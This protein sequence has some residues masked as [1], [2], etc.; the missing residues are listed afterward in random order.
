MNFDVQSGAPLELSTQ[1]LVVPVFQ[2]E[3]LSGVAA[4]LDTRLDGLV[5]EVKNDDGFKGAC[6]ETRVLYTNGKIASSR[7]ILV[8]LGKREKISATT[9][10]KAAAKAARGVRALKR[11]SFAFVVPDG[12]G[13]TSESL[14]VAL[15]EGIVLGL[16]IF[17]DFKTDAESKARTVIN[18]VTLLVDS[19]EERE[20]VARGVEYAQITTAANLRTRH[21]VNTPSNLKWPQTLADEAQK[22]ADEN[23][24][25]CT[26]WDENRIQAERMGALWGVGMGSD[27]PPRFIILEHIPQ[28]MENEPPLILVGKGMTFDTGG[29]SLKPSTSMEDMKDDMGGAAAVLGAMSVIGQLKPQRRIMALVASAENMVNGHAQRPGDIVTARNGKT[30]EVLNTDAEGRLILADT[31][32]YATEQKPAAIIDMATLT[33]A[34]GIALGQEAA[35]LFTNNDE[36]G[37]KVRAAGEAVGERVW[38]FPMWD[39]YREHVKGTASDIKNI[40]IERRA[41]SIA[42]AV[43]LEHF[44]GEGIPWVHL[45]I[46]AVAFLREDRPLVQ[47]GA[48]GFGARLILELLRT[49]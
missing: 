3:E 25:R 14:A 32:S 37:E 29:Y 48:T 28:G 36:L 44:V 38:P 47:R 10:R 26:I 7:V 27:K 21:L 9:I 22:I 18:N 17:D 35:G 2:N 33:G 8:G 20:N 23:G 12:I 46:A 39:E 42:G 24:L 40:G 5:R 16:H 15:A 13:E 30:I 11:D 49:L 45:D 34:I 4:E 1:C 43:F 41:G 6:G 19:G 31:L